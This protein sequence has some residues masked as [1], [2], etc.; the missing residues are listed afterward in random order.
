ME[1]VLQPDDASHG[2]NTAD[3]KKKPDDHV[4]EIHDVHM[5]FNDI[6]NR[7]K[8]KLAEAQQS[9]KEGNPDGQ[10]S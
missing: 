9:V 1:I 10:T 6:L 3:E 5:T 8:Q 7:A 4:L 2:Q